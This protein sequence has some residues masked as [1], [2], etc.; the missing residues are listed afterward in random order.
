MS[1]S[2]VPVAREFVT[3]NGVPELGFNGFVGAVA[4]STNLIEDQTKMLEEYPL[5]NGYW[6]SKVGRFENIEI[7]ACVTA[8]W[9]HIHL[10]G[11]INGF[12]KIRS[13]KKWLRV[14]RD[15]E[16]PDTYAWWNQE[17]LKRFLDRYLKGIRN[18]WEMTPKVRIEVMDAY[19][20][21][22][23]VN[24]AEKEFPLARTEYKKLYLDAS[25]AKAGGDPG[26]DRGAPGS[27]P[28]LSL[29]GGSLSAR[30]VPITSSVSYDA[31]EGLSTFDIS[32]E[33]DTEITGFLKAHLWVEAD[34]NDE[35]DL[36]LTVQK[37]DENGRFVPTFVLDEPHP[38]AWGWL[39]V[40]H[41]ALDAELSTDYQPVQS[42]KVQEKLRPGEIVPVDIAIYPT[43]RMWHNRVGA[44][45]TPAPT[46]PPDMRAPIRRFAEHPR[47]G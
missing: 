15:F 22:F 13:P 27:T 44:G 39:R 6:Q 38:G 12:R 11:S 28:E 8:G 16:W 4:R 33:E 40:S 19:D 26:T 37:L 47:A 10:R 30:P 46:T 32:L 35:M 36:S 18:G 41:R 42:H 24:R 5:M 21:D 25:T 3:S 2:A 9:S 23:Q 17:D 20:C 31:N 7:P 45:L 1:R 34:G 14:P 43:S 29:V